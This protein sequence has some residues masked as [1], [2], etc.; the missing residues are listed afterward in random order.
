M[1]TKSLIMA[2]IALVS[3][4]ASCNN[5]ENANN[6]RS[7]EP[8]H[9]TVRISSSPITR[10]ES[11]DATGKITYLTSG[12]IYFVDA[13]DQITKCLKLDA[14]TVED[15]SVSI[16]DI[17]STAGTTITNVPGNSTS[18]YVVGN[19]GAGIPTTGKF[20]LVKAFIVNVASQAD[21]G[22]E[23]NE[24]VANVTLY[25]GDSFTFPTASFY[26]DPIAAR[27]QIAKF[28]QKDDSRITSY[29]IAG[30]YINNYYETMHIDGTLVDPFSLVN[31]G[32]DKT[33]YGDNTGQYPTALK[34]ILYD[35][36]L[37]N[38]ALAEPPYTIAPFLTNGVWAYNV[39]APVPDG[40]EV[41]HIVIAIS[42]V[43]I[44]GTDNTTYNG[45]WY[46]TV[47]KYK[48]DG[49]EVLKFEPYNVYKIANIAFS[50]TDLDDR[51]EIK[52]LS[53][54]VTVQNRTWIGKE[55][56]AIF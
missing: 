20:S 26:I 11:T 24:I 48:V 29:K 12:Y 47:R 46:L 25:G 3:G 15:V 37:D 14:T 40:V 17:S 6:E 42:N 28:S 34:R 16:V 32:D 56:E 4:L 38:T 54:T 22:T 55:T 52:A 21:T 2:A 9:V 31:N 53:V 49:V 27:I 33:N 43:V 5:D 35:N 10:A 44:D 13:S 41:P 19:A 1:R 7:S 39:L 50:E 51:P 36:T 45:T 23:E 30:I 18:V 8:Q